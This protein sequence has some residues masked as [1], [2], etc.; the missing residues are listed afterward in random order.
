MT[1]VRQ[2]LLPLRQ[3]HLEAMKAA[4]EPACRDAAARALVALLEVEACCGEINAMRAELRMAGGEAT[5]LPSSKL[6]APIR[7]LLR[8]IVGERS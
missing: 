4:Y 7:Q 8:Q 1:R 6:M 2:S 3:R 5:N